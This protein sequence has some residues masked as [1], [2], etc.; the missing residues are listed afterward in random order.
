MASEWTP[1]LIM[2]IMYLFGS[3][4]FELVPD[5]GVAFLLMRVCIMALRTHVP[6]ETNLNCLF[7]DLWRI[8][9]VFSDVFGIELGR[10]LDGLGWVWTLGC[11]FL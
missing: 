8:Y 5:L 9:D 7:I 6:S 3:W 4:C 1:T 11:T 10:A 2:L